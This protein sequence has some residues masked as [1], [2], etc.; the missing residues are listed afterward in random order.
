VLGV[1][2]FFVSEY[3]LAARRYPMKSITF[4]LDKIRT[5]DMHC[6]GLDVGSIPEKAILRQLINEIGG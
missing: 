5:A 1:R 6:K 3:Q 4:V 2:P